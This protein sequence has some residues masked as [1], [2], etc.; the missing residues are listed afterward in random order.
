MILRTHTITLRDDALG[1]RPLTE[2]DWDI[3]L[4]WNRDP[5]VLYYAEGDDVTAYSLAEVQAI[6]RHVSQTA[7]C[8]VIELD[9]QPIGEGWLQQM[10]QDRIIQQHPDADCRRIDLLIGEKTQWGRGFGTRAIRLLTRFAFEQQQADL[11]FACDVA[12][13]NLRSQRAFE[14][15]GFTQVAAIPQPAGSKARVCYDYALSRADFTT[16]G[17]TSAAG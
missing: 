9:G 10:N 5:D 14:K 2:A 12:D 13:Y 15:V 11:V 17:R 6:Y 4:K 3:L 8:F 1:L 16:G 7:F